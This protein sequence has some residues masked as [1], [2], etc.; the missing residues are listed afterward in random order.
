[1]GSAVPVAAADADTDALAALALDDAD[2]DL[3]RAAEPLA[4][5][6]SEPVGD[7]PAD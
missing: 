6:V 5:C 3:V 4:V 1:M 2:G 7:L